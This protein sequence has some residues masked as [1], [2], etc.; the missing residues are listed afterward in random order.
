[1]LLH[2]F[3]LAPIERAWLFEDCVWHADLADIVEQ[4]AVLKARIVEKA[5]VNRRGEFE[6]VA[7]NT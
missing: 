2:Q 6:R 1:M 3:E 5:A 7:L 4:E